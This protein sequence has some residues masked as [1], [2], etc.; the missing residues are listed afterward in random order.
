MALFGY[1]DRNNL[2]D[3]DL[4]IGLSYE[5][6]LNEK[7]MQ[8]LSFAHPGN[9]A[10]KFTGQ[11]LGLVKYRLG[12]VKSMYPAWYLYSADGCELPE[13]AS[14]FY[15]RHV[16][17]VPSSSDGVYLFLH[18]ENIKISGPIKETMAETM[19]RCNVSGGIRNSRKR[20]NKRK[21]KRKTKKTVF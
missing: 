18:R 16:K 10:N 13:I 19:A 11:Y 2:D 21:N 4:I 5:I 17:I 14:L 1:K 15:F 9:T 8:M 7:L 12:G 20:K 6:N 3:D